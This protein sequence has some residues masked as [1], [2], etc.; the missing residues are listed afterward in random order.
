MFNSSITPGSLVGPTDPSGA[1]GASTGALST[2]GAGV[3]LS[4]ITPAVPAVDDSMFA[5]ITS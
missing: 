5:V 1:A 4:S 3:P 2:T